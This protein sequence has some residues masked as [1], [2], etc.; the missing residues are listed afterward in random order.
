MQKIPETMN[1]A[2]AAECLGLKRRTMQ[3]RRRRMLAAHSVKLGSAVRYRKEDL[4][5]FIDDSRVEPEEVL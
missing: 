3:D 1:E 2:M 5:A 4:D